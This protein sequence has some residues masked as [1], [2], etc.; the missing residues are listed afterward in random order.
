MCTPSLISL[1]IPQCKTIIV[2]KQVLLL[3]LS[4]IFSAAQPGISC[5]QVIGIKKSLKADK[6]LLRNKFFE[7]NR[8]NKHVVL[9]FC[10]GALPQSSLV[11]GGRRGF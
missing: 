7:E 11:L 5:I 4:F 10:K 9:E 8:P 2:L 3:T 6:E 1:E